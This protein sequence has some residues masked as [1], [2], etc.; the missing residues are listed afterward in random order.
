MTTIIYPIASSWIL[1]E[2]WLKSIDF[3]DAAGAGYIHLL[4]G[5]A[6]LVGTI[7]MGPRSGIFDNKTTVNKLVKAANQKR[8]QNKFSQHTYAPISANHK[9]VSSV[10]SVN[11]FTGDQTQVQ[12]NTN[13]A[14]Q[15][16]E[17][18]SFFNYDA[19]TASMKYRIYLFR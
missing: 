13:D 11:N 15:N 1:G 17:I 8:M 12:D 14:Q 2:G 4:G 16:K 6:G 5:V 19:E 9:Q 10:S 7:L 3:H 18:K